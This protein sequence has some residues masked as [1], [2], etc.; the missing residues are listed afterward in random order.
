MKSI[1][2]LAVSH[3]FSDYLCTS[4][5]KVVPVS[6]RTYG[7]VDVALTEEDIRA[8]I[9][10]HANV[11]QGDSELESVVDS[12]VE[13]ITIPDSETP[14]AH[15]ACSL[16][17]YYLKHPDIHPLRYIGTFKFL[18]FACQISSK[19]YN[20]HARDF[21]QYAFYFKGVQW[22]LRPGWVYI[23]FLD[24]DD[25]VP[26]SV[27]DLLDRAREGMTTDIDTWLRKRVREQANSTVASD[28][29]DDFS[30]RVIDQKEHNDAIARVRARLA[31]AA[32]DADADDSESEEESDSPI[33]QD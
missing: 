24:D 22:K 21:G 15:C 17:A 6:P 29:S 13:K 28:L 23:R 31:A 1:L 10:K 14:N 19:H 20:Q 4:T 33:T 11:T 8:V 2:R 30:L 26:K 32:A 12:F 27:I 7:R 3:R 25:T 16:L 9:R 5:L 18:C